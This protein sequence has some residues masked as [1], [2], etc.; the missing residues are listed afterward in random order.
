M[1]KL[2]VP[3][4]IKQ[5]LAG[6][7]EADGRIFTEFA[8]EQFFLM[9]EYVG[10]DPVKIITSLFSRAKNPEEQRELMADAVWLIR[11]FLT[12]GTNA[13]STG[14]SMFTRMSPEGVDK[15]KRLIARWGILTDKPLSQL[16]PG[17]VTPSRM[18]AVFSPFTAQILRNKTFFERTTYA[19]VDVTTPMPEGE[20][21]P[22]K[23]PEHLRFPGSNGLYPDNDQMQLNY[24]AWSK[25]FAQL[26]APKK[27]DMSDI[28]EFNRK[29]TH[30][31]E[32]TRH[33][34]PM[35]IFKISKE[36]LAALLV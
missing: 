17:D 11:L 13:R 18:I 4:E 25:R 1:A 23:L 29:V 33:S 24:L 3:D 6:L 10:F 28:I 16:E 8:L 14:K 15:A 30:F 22:S 36:T 5:L 26:I 7:I 21:D 27:P 12:R 34:N 35:R 31:A 2:L 32:V 9:T 19:R 20:G